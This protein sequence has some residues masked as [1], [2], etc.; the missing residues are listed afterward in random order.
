MV[1]DEK[2]RTQKFKRNQATLKHPAATHAFTLKA[3]TMYRASSD[4]TL[5]SS[6]DSKN[7]EPVPVSLQFT[8]E[9]ESSDYDI[10]GDFI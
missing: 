1:G 5:E 7:W 6:E 2:E 10:A 3:H 9:N 8:A 4:N